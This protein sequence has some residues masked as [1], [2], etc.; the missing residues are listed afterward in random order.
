MIY[1][2]GSSIIEDV[3]YIIIKVYLYCLIILRRYDVH[4]LLLVFN[5]RNFILI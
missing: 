5:V 1:L 3:D 4:I 2:N